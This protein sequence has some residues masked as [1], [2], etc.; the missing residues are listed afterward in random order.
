MSQALQEFAEMKPLYNQAHQLMLG[1]P[2]PQKP[3]EETLQMFCRLGYT[4]GAAPATPRRQVDKFV[5]T[6]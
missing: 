3:G 5:L 6:P 1:K 2:A 4:P